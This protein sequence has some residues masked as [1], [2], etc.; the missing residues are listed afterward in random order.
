MKNGRLPNPSGR[1]GERGAQAGQ[2]SIAIDVAHPLRRVKR[3]VLLRN[4]PEV[5][6]NQHLDATPVGHDRTM[7]NILYT[8]C[9]IVVV[10]CGM[11]SIQDEI[12]KVF[13]PSRHFLIVVL[14]IYSSSC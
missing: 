4:L 9:Y 1:G 10:R 8:A 7:P 6:E 11:S 13:T 12:L 5:V 3:R 14:Y 2:A